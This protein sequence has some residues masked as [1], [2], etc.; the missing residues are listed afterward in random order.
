VG[1]EVELK[2][3]TAGQH[4]GPELAIEGVCLELL[5]PMEEHNLHGH[6]P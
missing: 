5:S 3:Y 1:R 4:S 6:C 2:L